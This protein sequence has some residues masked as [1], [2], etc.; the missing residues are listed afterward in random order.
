MQIRVPDN[1][2]T[3]SILLSPNRTLQMNRDVCG[4]HRD[5]TFNVI[6]VNQANEPP[7]N[8]EQ[9]V[10]N[11][12]VDSVQQQQLP[13]QASQAIMVDYY[14]LCQEKLHQVQHLQWRIHGIR[15]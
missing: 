7:V 3:V 11:M 4:L 5:I 13:Q 14:S 9:L 15:P 1:V 2:E 6:N 8:Q 12:R 10:S